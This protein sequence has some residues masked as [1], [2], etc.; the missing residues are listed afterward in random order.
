M[1]DFSRSPSPEMSEALLGLED[2]QLEAL[3]EYQDITLLLDDDKA[4]NILERFE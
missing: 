2:Y 3:E 4:I 1:S